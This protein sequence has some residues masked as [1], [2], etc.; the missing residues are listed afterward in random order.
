M[1]I[2]FIPPGGNYQPPKPDLGASRSDVEELKDKFERL[3]LVTMAVWTFVKDEKEI[4]EDALIARVR[5]IDKLDGTADG[6]L[7]L[8]V[9][10]C[11]KCGK[12]LNPKFEKCLYC[13]HITPVSSIFETF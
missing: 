3:K 2:G 5:E 13:G 9:K 4:N 7:R 1:P 12:T 8:G 6:K 11:G 10:K